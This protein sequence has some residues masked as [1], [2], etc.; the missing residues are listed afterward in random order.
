MQ[1]AK[2]D[3]PPFF[4]HT[5]KGYTAF[6]Q[7]LENEVREVIFVRKSI[8]V[9]LG[10]FFVGVGVNYFLVPHQ[11]MDGGMIGIGLLAKYYFD[12]PPGL[13]M[14]IVSLPVYTVVFLYDRTLFY[15]SFHG[16]LLTSLVIDLLSPLRGYNPFAVQTSAV[17]G[18]A[19]IG[20][21]IGWMLAYETNTGGTDLLAQFL[22]RR[23]G[24][25]V[26]LLIFLI[27]GLIIGCSLEAIGGYKTA[28]S[29]IT[30]ISVAVATHY[31]SQ[32]EE[33]RRKKPW[34]VVGPFRRL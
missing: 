16:M 22:A 20:A 8:A 11:L 30:I 6:V 25:S 7:L 26:A 19:L 3:I 2:P 32:I 33:R 5:I 24:F 1:A 10:S 17:L 29:L 13:I 14:L 9:S 18:G 27:D 21:G 12:W 4:W 28:F 23:T 15:N 34:V 31:F